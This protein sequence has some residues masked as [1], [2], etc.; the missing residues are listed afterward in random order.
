MKNTH[1]CF[2]C[3]FHFHYLLFNRWP[4]DDPVVGSKLFALCNNRSPFVVFDGFFYIYFAH[5]TG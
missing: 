2:S 4:D 5:T 3:T 1:A